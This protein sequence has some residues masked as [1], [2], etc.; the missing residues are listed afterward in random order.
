MKRAK[1]SGSRVGAAPWARY[2]LWIVPAL[3]G[4]GIQRVAVA[5]PVWAERYLAR[6][7]FR[8]CAWPVARVSSWVPFSLTELAVVVGIPL[9]LVLGIRSLVRVWRAPAKQR[10]EH[11]GKTTRR[12]LW[13]LSCTVLLFMLFHGWNYTRQ[14]LADTLEW[15]IRPRSAAELAR[16]AQTLAHETSRLREQVAEDEKGVMRLSRGIEATLRAAADVFDAAAATYPV[17]AGAPVRPK[18]VLLSHYWSYTGITGMYFPFFVEAN[19]NVDVPDSSLPDTI[20]HEIAHT[21]GFAREDEAGFL[22]FLTGSLSSEVDFQ[23]AVTLQGF[24]S[25]AERLYTYD[26]PAWEESWAGIS[27]AVRRDLAAESAYWQAFEG[28]VRQVSEQVNDTYLQANLQQDGVHSYGRKADLILA[29]LDATHP[30]W[31]AQPAGAN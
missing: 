15:T 30:E 11:L 20:L 21:R 16:A 6:G 10:R 12:L 17:L 13:V 9:A 7:L 25:L 29:Y 2:I 24:L 1:N 26:R 28:P 27:A 5:H 22:A 23:Y 8:V 14:P 4:I 31:Q 18:G 3:L 19:V